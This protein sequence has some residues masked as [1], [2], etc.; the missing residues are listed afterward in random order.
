MKHYKE[1]EN[2][3]ISEAIKAVKQCSKTPNP[4]RTLRTT[5]PE[6]PNIELSLTF[7]V[8]SG[9]IIGSL[10]K[11][12]DYKLGLIKDYTVAKYIC[13]IVGKVGKCQFRTE[14]LWRKAFGRQTRNCANLRA[15]VSGLGMEGV[16]IVITLQT[17]QGNSAACAK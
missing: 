1:E 17:R 8:L 10:G 12:L 11:K 3:L 14:R 7:D 9:E 4:N 13:F 5:P 6:N 16:V 2:R 15:V